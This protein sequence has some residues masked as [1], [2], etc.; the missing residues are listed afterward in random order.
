MPTCISSDC[1]KYASMRF[2]LLIVDLDCWNGIQY[3]MHHT[4]TGP[5]S[6]TPHRD[7]DNVKFYN[8]YLAIS[9]EM[10]SSQTHKKQYGKCHCLMSK[11]VI[12]VWNR[13]VILTTCSQATK[14]K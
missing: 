9:I 13:S 5:L 14:I 1:L 12:Y 7:N 10:I 2:L 11:D 3:Q 8:K 6:Y 4:A